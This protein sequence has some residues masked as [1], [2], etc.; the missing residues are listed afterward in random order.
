M[1]T[2][3]GIGANTAVFSLVETVLLRTLPVEEPGGRR[4]R[5]DTGAARVLDRARETLR[6]G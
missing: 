1:C 2:D 6:R 4:G 3:P 5:L